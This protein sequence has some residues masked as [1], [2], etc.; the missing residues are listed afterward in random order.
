MSDEEREQNTLSKQVKILCIVFWSGY[1]R[2]QNKVRKQTFSS[3]LDTNYGFMKLTLLLPFCLGDESLHLLV[4]Q[5]KNEKK[6]SSLKLFVNS[7]TIIYLLII[8]F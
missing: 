2:M 1:L 3:A 6:Q 5:L 7:F 4:N 8:N